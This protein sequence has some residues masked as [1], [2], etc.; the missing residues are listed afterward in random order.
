MMRAGCDT[1]SSTTAIRS[2]PATAQQQ[3][4]HR[5][6][7]N[8]HASDNHDNHYQHGGNNHGGDDDDNRTVIGVGRRGSLQFF[9]NLIAL[10]IIDDTDPVNAIVH[11]HGD[12]ATSA[13]TG[14]TLTAIS[15]SHPATVAVTAGGGELPAF[16]NNHYIRMDNMRT[17]D[18][19]SIVFT[20]QRRRRERQRGHGYGDDANSSNA[21]STTLKTQPNTTGGG[22]GTTEDEKKLSRL[23]ISSST[24]SDGGKVATS[25][26]QERHKQRRRRQQQQQQQRQER[27]E[28]RRRHERSE[29]LLRHE[30]HKGDDKSCS[31]NS[32]TS[33]ADDVDYETKF[34]L[35]QKSYRSRTHLHRITKATTTRT[36]RENCDYEHRYDGAKRRQDERPDVKTRGIVLHDSKRSLSYRRMMMKKKMT[37]KKT[38][39]EAEK[40][41]RAGRRRREVSSSS[42]ASPAEAMVIATGMLASAAAAGEK[43]AQ[44]TEEGEEEG[45]KKCS[46]K[47]NTTNYNR[48]LDPEHV[49]IPQKQGDK[50]NR[51]NTSKRHE[52]KIRGE[53]QKTDT[54]L[55]V[56]NRDTATTTGENN[57]A[58]TSSMPTLIMSKE[59]TW[60]KKSIKVTEEGKSKVSELTS[61]TDSYNSGALMEKTTKNKMEGKL[62]HREAVPND[63]NGTQE[64][65]RIITKNQRQGD[66]YADG[67]RLKSDSMFPTIRED[68]KNCAEDKEV[69]P[70]VKDS[71]SSRTFSSSVASSELEVEF[72]SRPK[73]R[74][75][76]RELLRPLSIPQ[77]KNISGCLEDK[78]NIFSFHDDSSHLTSTETDEKNDMSESSVGT[79]ASH[80]MLDSSLTGLSDEHELNM[81]LE[82]SLPSIF[83]LSREWCADEQ[84]ET[85]EMPSEVVD[86]PVPQSSILPTYLDRSLLTSGGISPSLAG[87]FAL[88]HR[89]FLRAILQIL[90]ERDRVGV[91]ADAD[92]PNTIKTGPL[93]KSSK[94]IRGSAWKVKYVEIRSGMFSY[95]ENSLTGKVKRGAS[96]VRKN[97]RLRANMCTCRAVDKTSLASKSLRSARG[98]V[99]ELRVE[100]EPRRLW[101]ANSREERQAW[102]RAIH[103]AM[104][105]SSSTTLLEPAGEWKIGSAFFSSFRQC[106]DADQYLRLQA[107]V[108]KASTKDDYLSSFSNLWGKSLRLPMQWIREHVEGKEFE[109]TG[110]SSSSYCLR[111]SLENG[112]RASLSQFWHGLLRGPVVINGHMLNGDSGH[113]PERIVGA[114]SR[115][116]LEFDKSA[117]SMRWTRG[118]GR[119]ESNTE[120]LE[121]ISEV[122]AIS[123]ARDVLMAC[124]ICRNSDD[125]YYSVDSLCHHLNLVTVLPGSSLTEPIHIDVSLVAGGPDS[126]HGNSMGSNEREKTGWVS[127]RTK[128][129]KPWKNFFCVMSEGVLTFYEKE[130]PRPHGLLDQIVLVGATLNASVAAAETDSHQESTAESTR[131]SYILSITNHDMSKESQMSFENK[132][133]FESW[134]HGILLAIETCSPASDFDPSTSNEVFAIVA[135]ETA[136]TSDSKVLDDGDILTLNSSRKK[137]NP[138]GVNLVKATTDMF[139]GL[140]RIPLKENKMLA[141]RGKTGSSSKGEVPSEITNSVDTQSTTSDTAAQSMQ[142]RRRNRAS[143]RMSLSFD[144]SIKKSEEVF[145]EAIKR[146][147]PTVQIT[148][149]TT[150]VYKIVTADPVGEEKKDVW[151]II[152]TKVTQNFLL[153]GGRNGRSSKGDEVVELNFD[154]RLS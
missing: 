90:E 113:G 5:T 117:T 53:K 114:L 108:K 104:I 71:I 11:V 26:Q 81:Q 6:P 92:D 124:S 20:K 89:I 129:Q 119:D 42:F 30:R 29:L 105:G 18:V 25:M 7:H 19:N 138:S 88:E 125:A 111:P 118:K 47:T 116:I 135:D 34:K 22:E 73:R 66:F 37:K 70:T 33:P 152:R 149:R 23:L 2:R 68:R 65:S 85:E 87:R 132:N 40:K 123:Y 13:A 120:S 72:P 147:G 52:T 50:L 56:G 75:G 41:K 69:E 3:N 154:K 77:D 4:H 141:V 74:R 8:H 115:C 78:G 45:R 82:G 86:A 48:N 137:S 153:S 1:A 148:V 49:N 139:R 150:S 128:T 9:D 83:V 103:E 98:Y 51:Q 143:L 14:T 80:A 96:L 146:P 15:V 35:M 61:T 94:V 142:T 126:E 100:G 60:P 59:V 130:H 54:S 36:R 76:G 109:E 67:G 32:S 10:G 140:N 28:Q 112:S 24:S 99:F 79:E 46:R 107:S 91:E 62:K 57:T 101:L 16:L 55:H 95:Y 144:S 145:H 136:D 121:H 93:K 133:E 21:L 58:F 110:V 38:E 134:R 84:F 12:D 64:N 131:V 127:T 17:E 39:E 106:D 31:S 27:S 102:I 122:Q 63:K 43:S 151:T 97:L 44:N